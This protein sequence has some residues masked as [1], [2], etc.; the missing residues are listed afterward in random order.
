MLKES[1]NETGSWGVRDSPSMTM[2]RA[3]REELLVKVLNASWR[4]V[5]A[6]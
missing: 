2:G 6:E 4:V 5:E 1:V 3:K